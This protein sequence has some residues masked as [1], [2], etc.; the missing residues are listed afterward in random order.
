VTGC[1]RDAHYA[2]NDGCS[3]CSDGAQANDG[4]LVAQ[5]LTFC[6]KDRQGYRYLP[7]LILI[8]SNL[9]RVNSRWVDGD[10]VKMAV[11]R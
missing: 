8:L 10:R 11:Y 2:K 4:V 6:T 3:T 1:R 9:F 5:Q 7:S